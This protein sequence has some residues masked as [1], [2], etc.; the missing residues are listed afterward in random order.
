MGS[1]RL[2]CGVEAYFAHIDVLV[3][4]RQ[5]ANRLTASKNAQGVGVLKG[6][7]AR[8]SAR[9]LL[10]M[11]ILPGTPAGNQISYQFKFPISSY[12]L[13][14]ELFEMESLRLFETEVGVVS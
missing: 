14:R 13:G 1:L 6:G 2:S 9:L 11:S 5:A 4:L 8:L 10:E 7:R 12:L 3:A